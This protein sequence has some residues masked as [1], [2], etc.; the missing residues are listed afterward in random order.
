MKEVKPL[1]PELVQRANDASVAFDFGNM[2]TKKYESNVAEINTMIHL[3][4]QRR[5]KVIENLFE[6]RT[7]ELR[8]RAGAIGPYTYG[9]AK[10][11]KNTV[12]N[13][14]RAAHAAVKA[15]SYMN[16]LWKEEQKARKVQKHNDL[17]TAI[18]EADEK[19]L[20]QISIHDKIYYKARNSWTTK[21]PERQIK[22]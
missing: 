14:D 7:D 6:L 20:K 5:E 21:E 19:G 15:D 11:A 4:E 12:H 2:I 16:S 13:L 18:R 10:I 8:M 1:S 3:D 22:R 9:P 17:V